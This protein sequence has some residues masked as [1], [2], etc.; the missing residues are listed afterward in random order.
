MLNKSIRTK[1]D[2]DQKLGSSGFEDWGVVRLRSVSLC[3]SCLRFCALWCCAGVD[4]DIGSTLSIYLSI[5]KSMI[6]C[7][8]SHRLGFFVFKSMTKLPRSP[9]IMINAVSESDSTSKASICACSLFVFWPPSSA[10]YV[11]R[12]PPTHFTLVFNSA[13]PHYTR[14]PLPPT[15]FW[16]VLEMRLIIE[17]VEFVFHPIT[18]T[19]KIRRKFPVRGLMFFR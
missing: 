2:K 19:P 9:A 10:A 6:L 12:M 1:G 17:V 18:I 5:S 8:K 13:I 4:G 11:V 7:Y 14:H 3:V 16:A 15:A